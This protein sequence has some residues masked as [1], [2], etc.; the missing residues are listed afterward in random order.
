MSLAISFED[1]LDNM[2]LNLPYISRASYPFDLI[3]TGV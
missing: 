3:E 2:G 1:T